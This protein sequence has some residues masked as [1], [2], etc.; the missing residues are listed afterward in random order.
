[1]SEPTPMRTCATIAADIVAAY[2][3]TNALPAAELP[4]LITSV[5][6]KVAALMS[7]EE[8][9]VVVAPPA[10]KPAVPISKSITPDF[11]ICLED[12]KKF[13]SL[14]RHLGTVYD[15]TPA[16]YRAKWGL[17]PD[18][19]MVAPAYSAVRSQLAKGIGLGRRGVAA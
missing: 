17:P 7:G 5:R 14:K 2:V 13:R 8:P 3:A 18:Y 10:L 15:L 9:V 12:G 11:L 16:A 1:M 4:G 19:P 6:T